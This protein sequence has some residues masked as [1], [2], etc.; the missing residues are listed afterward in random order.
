MPIRDWIFKNKLTVKDFAKLLGV[1]RSY[2]YMWLNG[3]K[4]P[5]EKMLARIKELTN[6]QVQTFED[7]LEHRGN[8]NGQEA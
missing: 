6:D 8:Y 3:D 1:D 4:K 5:S 7:L 2:V